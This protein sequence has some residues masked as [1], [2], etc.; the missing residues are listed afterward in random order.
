MKLFLAVL[1]MA[2]AASGAYLETDPAK[3]PGVSAPPVPPVRPVPGS[4]LPALAQRVT[5]GVPQ[6]WSHLT[7]YPLELPSRHSTM[8]ILTLD[9]ALQRDQLAIREVGDG[10][11][12]R[13]AVRN[14]AAL[15]VLLMAGE[16]ILGG[17]QNRMVRDDVLLPRQS[18]WT[19]VTVYC[20]EEHRW[21]ETGG[22]RSGQ[23]LSAPALRQMATGGATQ[24]RIWSTIGEQLDAA[25]VETPTASYQQLFESPELQRR[26]DACVAAVRPLPGPRTVGC[27]VVRHRRILGGDLF[28]DPDLFAALW[29]KLCRSYAAEGIAPRPPIDLY[30]KHLPPP[31]KGMAQRFL[32]D[33]AR[34]RFIRRGTAG[35]GKLWKVHGAVE[36]SSLEH[37]GGVVHAGVFPARITI[38]PMPRLNSEE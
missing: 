26:L 10:Q 34:A 38:Q 33:I 20:G 25:R 1:M 15:P 35:I 22:F 29:P 7:F 17:K 13:L 14:D 16:L 28:G 21:R 24:D 2:V 11:V 31:E 4:M 37:F 5:I 9:Q 18:G 8:G 36:G 19:D 30:R 3:S 6:R 32:V 12:S 23:T 27:I